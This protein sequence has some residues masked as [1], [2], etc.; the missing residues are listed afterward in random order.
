MQKISVYIPVYNGAR[1]L[2]K[3]LRAVFL[4]THPFQEVLIVD[5]GSCDNL[6]EVI[7]PYNVRVIRL[8]KNTGLGNARNVGVLALHAELVASV[9]SDCELSHTWVERCLPFFER[10]DVV[11]VGGRLNE[12]G[13][14]GADAWRAHNLVQHF[15]D[16][17]KEVP[18]LSGSNTIFRKE[19]LLKAGMYNVIFTRNHEDTE[20]SE[21]LVQNGG[22]LLYVPEAD[23]L[24]RKHDTLYSVMRTSWGFRHRTYPR[25]VR[26]LAID[27]ARECLHS[28]RLILRSIC[29]CRWSSVP[30][31]AV[32]FLMQ[33]YFSIKAFIFK[34]AHI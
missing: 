10:A 21:R 16:Q 7:D 12:E 14:A 32:Y 24:H 27:I 26:E 20:L 11:G 4:Q 3:T 15:G 6:H 8:D 25:T 30:Y 33:S 5:D 19:A 1:Y 13:G 2:D 18:F 29:H 22:V 9:D 17:I 23:V 34:T 28:C 31:D